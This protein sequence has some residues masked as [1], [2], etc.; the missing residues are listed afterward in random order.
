MHYTFSNNFVREK[1]KKEVPRYMGKTQK[2][3]PEEKKYEE[4][5][6]N[7]SMSFLKTKGIKYLRRVV[8]TPIG[9]LERME[10]VPTKQLDI[11]KCIILRKANDC[12]RS[13]VWCT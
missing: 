12:N 9:N 7:I 4:K 8:S 10:T 1:T 5:F 2:L 11:G 6:K 13:F 3:N